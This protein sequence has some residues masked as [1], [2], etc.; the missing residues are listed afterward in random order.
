VGVE[1]AL[2][3]LATAAEEVAITE[4]DITGANPEDY[5]NV[6][7]ACY[8]VPSCVGITVWG[9]RDAD[10]YRSQDTPLLFDNNWAPKD[11]FYS[12]RDYLGN[13]KP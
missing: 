2:R 3:L 13:I 11:A 6:V 5:R 1:S 7:R 12:I 9:I 4:L 8:N 10:S